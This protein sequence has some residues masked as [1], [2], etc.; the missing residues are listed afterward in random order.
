LG[1][2]THGPLF[3]ILAAKAAIYLAGPHYALT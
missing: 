2:V 3:P 1:A